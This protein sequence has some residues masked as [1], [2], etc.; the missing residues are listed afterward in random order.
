M[1]G[2]RIDRRSVH[3][4]EVTVTVHRYTI[5]VFYRAGIKALPFVQRRV[6]RANRRAVGTVQVPD[7]LELIADV[8]VLI[9]GSRY[10]ECVAVNVALNAGRWW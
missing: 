9:T 6:S 2:I 1:S 7:V 3:A 8:D 4:T 10:S 5:Y